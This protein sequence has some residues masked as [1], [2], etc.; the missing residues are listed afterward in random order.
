VARRIRHNV[1][2]PRRREKS[3][4]DIDGDLLLAL[5]RKTVE[6]GFEARAFA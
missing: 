6:E 3:V 5:D 4:G 2:A 1:L